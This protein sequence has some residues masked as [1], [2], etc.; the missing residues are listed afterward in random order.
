MWSSRWP[1]DTI[2]H[3]LI[4]NSGF[5]LNLSPQIAVF[6]NVGL[7]SG[8]W[9]RRFG[10]EPI[11]R[12]MK[13]SADAIQRN[14]GYRNDTGSLY[15]PYYPYEFVT[16]RKLDSLH[17]ADLESPERESV[18]I[19]KKHIR[20]PIFIFKSRSTN[21]EGKVEKLKH[22]KRAL[23]GLRHA[24]AQWFFGDVSLSIFIF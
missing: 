4:Q 13:L 23:F 14:E 16:Y 2:Y 12:R 9:T 6:E 21:V 15:T 10:P 20:F 5:F 22:G 7:R 8:S 17:S 1:A 3:T 18:L 24:R 19:W 11:F